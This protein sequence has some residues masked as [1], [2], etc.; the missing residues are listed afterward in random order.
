VD[1]FNYS[2]KHI[3]NLNDFRFE[4]QQKSIYIEWGTYFERKIKKFH[5]FHFIKM[6]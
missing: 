3:N 5:F 4:Q 6:I 1:T 2:S